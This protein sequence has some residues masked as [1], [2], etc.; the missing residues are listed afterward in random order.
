[1]T[2]ARSAFREFESYLRIVVGLDE[3][4]IQLISKQIVSNFINY[5]ILRGY[6][7]IKDNSKAVYTMG[8][9]EGTPRIEYND[10]S[11]KTKLI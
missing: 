7:T 9:H 1:M 11:M 3:D 5:E 2:Y 10:F 6:Y 4:D 8:D